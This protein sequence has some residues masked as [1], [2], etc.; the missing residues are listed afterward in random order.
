MQILDE[1]RSC[2]DRYLNNLTILMG[3]KKIGPRRK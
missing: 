2:T 3:G 1:N